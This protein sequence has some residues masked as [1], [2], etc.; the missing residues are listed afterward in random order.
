VN[1]ADK[2]AKK[3]TVSVEVENQFSL[4]VN[5]VF[6]IKAKRHLILSASATRTP[7]LRQYSDI[8]PKKVPDAV[9]VNLL[10]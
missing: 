3:Y 2:D 10:R 4:A 1:F 7:L 8:G 5:E 9:R 6:T